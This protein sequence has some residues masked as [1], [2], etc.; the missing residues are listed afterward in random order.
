M[1]K[2]WDCTRKILSLCALHEVCH[3]EMTRMFQMT[4]KGTELTLLDSSFHKMKTVG[5][6]VEQL[7]LKDM[8]PL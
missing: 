2:N 6:V 1:I 4:L 5:K 8:T 3:M 7:F